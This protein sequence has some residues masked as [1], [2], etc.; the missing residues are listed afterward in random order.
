MC[1]VLD[2]WAGAAHRR[3][4]LSAVQPEPL[5]WNIKYAHLSWCDQD[6]H[7]TYCMLVYI[8]TIKCVVDS[9]C[10][11][12]WSLQLLCCQALNCR[13]HALSTLNTLPVSITER[14]WPEFN[15]IHRNYLCESVLLPGSGWELITN[16]SGV[17]ILQ[18]ASGAVQQ[19]QLCS[20]LRCIHAAV[21]W[22]AL[23]HYTHTTIAGVSIHNITIIA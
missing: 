18:G 3:V 2:V 19:L 6:C 12:L 22:H 4:A 23:H 7:C 14:P 13:M 5:A 11:W 20:A 8:V 17:W 1:P 10:A 9:V 16:A 21:R 15:Q